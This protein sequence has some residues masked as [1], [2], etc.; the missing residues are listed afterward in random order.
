MSLRFSSPVSITLRWMR[1]ETQATFHGMLDH[2]EKY[3]NRAMDRIT[4]PAALLSQRL[5]MHPLR[6]KQVGA[7]DRGRSV[8]RHL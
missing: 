4:M 3:A 2:E 6:Q 1:I 7:G 5:L 8:V